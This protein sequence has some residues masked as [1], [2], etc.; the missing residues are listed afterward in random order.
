MVRVPCSYILSWV[1]T[2]G[3]CQKLYQ[4]KRTSGINELNKKR[5]IFNDDF[6]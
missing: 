1:S 4:V 3:H 5:F 2:A 6:A